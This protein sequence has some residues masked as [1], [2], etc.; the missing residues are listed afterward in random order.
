MILCGV[1]VVAIHE[2]RPYKQIL[3][4]NPRKLAFVSQ[5]W[6]L[7]R[8]IFLLLQGF[9][10]VGWAAIVP[11]AHVREKAKE[12]GREEPLCSGGMGTQSTCCFRGMGISRSVG[13]PAF[14]LPCNLDDQ[15]TK[16][17]VP[18]RST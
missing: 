2:L 10:L 4:I 3:S 7:L 17:A 15:T 13:S 14:L 5:G 8:A 9:I 11:R 12:S 6:S 1:L 18:A 16:E